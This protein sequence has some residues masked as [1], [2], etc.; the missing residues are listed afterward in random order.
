MAPD[1]T[2]NTYLLEIDGNTCYS[3]G[4]GSSIPANSWTWVDYQNGTTSSK[5]NATLSAGNHTFKMIGNAPDLKLDRIVTTTDT[6]CTPSGTGDNCANPADTTP[7]TA[8]ITS[9]TGGTVKGTVTVNASASD[10]SGTVS[11]VAFFVDDIQVGA[12]DT[13]SPYSFSWNTATASN[14][15]H[16]LTVKATDPS[17]NVGTSASV[18]VTVDNSA[19]TVS[20]TAP[21]NGATVS[22]TVN[23][24]AT[25]SDN[26]GVTSVEF[27]RGST[28]MAS[29]STSPYSYSWNTSAVANGSYVLT[30]K[31]YDAA[32]NVTTSS[33]V[34]VTVNNVVAPPPDTTPPTTSITSP[35]NGSTAS[36]TVTVNASA[37][38]AVGVTKVELYIDGSLA[39]TDV[40]SPYSFSWNTASYSN[41]AH[42]LVT[43]AYDAAGN[44]GSS[45]TVTVTVNN[46]VVT[47]KSGDVNNDGVINALDAAPLLYNW[48]KSGMSRAQG[49]LNGD[50]VVNAVDASILLFNWGK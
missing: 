19:P 26:I 45:S 24:S 44:V 48:G 4:G 28:L 33:N 49:D 42:T 14:G 40:A 47:P 3:V 27:Y 35:A 41:A 39:A 8:S 31:A 20:L 34:T 23:L 21:A 18:V 12:A 7:P 46:T 2:N 13:T 15:T 10:D 43:K 36:G 9:P 37:A 30:A 5:I 25:A 11:Q 16:T 1:T 50:G 17:G 6:A 32:G 29:D 22:G 38:D